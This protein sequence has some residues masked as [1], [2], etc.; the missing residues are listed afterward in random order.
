MDARML[1]NIT[2]K[3]E[4]LKQKKARA[5]GGMENITKDWEKL[6]D[7]HTL[8]DAKAKEISINEQQV[9]V[10]TEMDELFTELLGLANW[11]LV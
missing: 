7:V 9:A 3:V 11:D 2:N 10:D 6:F 5:E 1:E 4:L 8:E